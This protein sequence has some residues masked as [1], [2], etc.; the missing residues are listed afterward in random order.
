MKPIAPFP[1]LAAGLLALAACQADKLSTPRATPASAQ[2]AAAG[3]PMAPAD[4]ALLGA[5][6][7]DAADRLAPALPDDVIGAQL[8]AD[9][10]RLSAALAAGNAA[11]ARSALGAA[12]ATLGRAGPTPDAAAIALALDRVEALLADGGLEHP[13]AVRPAAAPP[14]DGLH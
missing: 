5:G 6:I 8:A 13:G 12:R 9:L 3:I 14:A 11:G 7:D 1:L 2:P 4:A 10:R